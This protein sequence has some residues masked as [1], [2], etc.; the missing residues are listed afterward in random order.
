MKQLIK[1]IIDKDNPASSKRFVTLL[2][3]L[4]FILSSFAVLFTSFYVIFHIPKG[5]LDERL[6]GVLKQI[7]DY[8][9]YIILSGL[10]FITVEQAGTVLIEF[11][12][13]KF[14]IK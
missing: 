2:I 3:A 1:D 5:Q 9:F 12:K 4:H 10:S 14:G 6:L 13:N 8:D 11:I 7:L